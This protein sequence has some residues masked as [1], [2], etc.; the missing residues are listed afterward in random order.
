MKK[1]N[2]QILLL[3]LSVLSISACDSD[4]NHDP[5][6]NM[7]YWVTFGRLDFKD[8]NTFIANYK[9]VYNMDETEYQNWCDSLANYQSYEHFWNA[10]NDEY[11]MLETE[12]DYIQFKEDYKDY[13]TF[14]EE[15]IDGLPDYSFV[16]NILNV[17]LMRLVN[18]EGIFNIGSKTYDTKVEEVIPGLK[19]TPDEHECYKRDGKRKMWVRIVS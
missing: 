19:S 1:V 7:D 5:F 11:E 2:K 16:P 6:A 4:K 12:A 10:I 9:R 18:K 8:Y 3:M 17:S 15:T 14:S 13:V